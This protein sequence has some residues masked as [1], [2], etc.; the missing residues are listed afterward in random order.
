M[1]S[2][3]PSVYG[4]VTMRRR[5][6]SGSARH[7]PRRHRSS[8]GRARSAIPMWGG[9]R[10]SHSRRSHRGRGVWDVLKSIGRTVG[11]HILP[12]A[13]DIGVSLIKKRFGLGRRRRSHRSRSLGIPRFSQSRQIGHSRRRRRTRR[14]S[15][16]GG[17]RSVFSATRGMRRR[18]RRRSRYGGS[19]MIAGASRRR[20]RTRRVRGSRRHRS[21]R[22]R[23]GRG[24]ISNFL[25]GFIPF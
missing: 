1:P 11:P 3:S 22:V 13:R 9:R 17:L 5:S 21:R 8:R 10:R 15:R 4:G 12:I 2:F 25:S 18:T 20:R 14:S 24:P 7:R 16:R 6:L 19:R 23:R